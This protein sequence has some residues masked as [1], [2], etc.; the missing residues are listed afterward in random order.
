[1]WQPPAARGRDDGVQPGVAEHIGHEFKF[2][3]ATRQAFVF[4]RRDAPELCINFALTGRR[5]KRRF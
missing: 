2:Q 5:S 3:T 1:M 4:S